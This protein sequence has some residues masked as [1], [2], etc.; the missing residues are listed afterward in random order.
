[1]ADL[2]SR[3][4][5]FQAGAREV[6]RRSETRTRAQRV[7]PQAVFTPGTDI[8]IILAACS[9]MGDEVTRHLSLRLAALYLDSA[10]RE[11]LDR[12]VTDRF[13]RDL[14]RKQAA[15]AVVTLTFTRPI[16]PSSGAGGSLNVGTKI[17]TKGGTEFTLV[18]SATFA[19][20]S[21]GPVTAV[22]QAVL[23]GEA[24]NVPIGSIVEFSQPPFDPAIIVTNAEPAAGGTD[25]ET[26]A[27]YR[28]RARDFYRAARRGILAAIEFGALTVPGV[29]AAVAEELLDPSGLPNGIVRVYISDKGGQSNQVLAAAVR[30]A[31]L[32]FRAAG[33]IVDVLTTVPA[34][35]SIAYTLAFRVGTDQQAAIQQLK[36]LTVNAVNLLAPQEPLQRSMLFAL[37]RSIPGAVVS[38]QAVTTPTGDVLPGIAQTIRT[39]MDRVTVN[40]V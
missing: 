36:A 5:L 18:T 40:G 12:L 20:A 28:S 14:V 39:S 6:F 34:F 22:G 26:D 1:M 37:A 32:E 15:P 27:N 19:A 35:E 33:I 16:P 2:P 11:D 29:Y 3:E 25:V 31:L 24:G 4:D 23:S 7:N 13:S 30:R 17:R 8:N 10:E 21:S 9:A 38:E